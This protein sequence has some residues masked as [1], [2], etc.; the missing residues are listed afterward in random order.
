MKGLPRRSR[1]ECDNTRVLPTNES[2]HFFK[3]ELALAAQDDFSQLQIIFKWTE[4]E[5]SFTRRVIERDK[6]ADFFFV[7]P[8]SKFSAKQKL[9]E[10]RIHSRRVCLLLQLRQDS[11]I[12]ISNLL[13]QRTLEIEAQTYATVPSAIMAPKHRISPICTEAEQTS[14]RIVSVLPF[15]HDSSDVPLTEVDGHQ[16]KRIVQ[17]RKAGDFYTTKCNTADRVLGG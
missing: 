1:F 12:F 6:H 4:V 3:R 8:M 5:L 11:I 2:S 14:V 9:S 17:V 7:R 10:I 15:S 16:F 13:G